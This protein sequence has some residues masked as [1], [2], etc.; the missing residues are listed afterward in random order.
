MGWNNLAS[1]PKFDNLF[2]TIFKTATSDGKKALYRLDE[3][4]F[5]LNWQKVAVN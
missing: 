2:W 3:K 1:L 5:D 4:Y